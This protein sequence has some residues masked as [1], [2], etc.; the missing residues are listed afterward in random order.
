MNPMVIKA[1]K[2]GV[3]V[4]GVVV[5]IATAY[6]DKKDREALIA[7]EVAKAIAKLN[8]EEV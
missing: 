7:K 4:L 8:K 3:K 5:P 6:F 1:A 2:I